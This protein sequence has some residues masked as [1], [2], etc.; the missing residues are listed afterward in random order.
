MSQNFAEE[1]VAADTVFAVGPY[2]RKIG[3]N[4]LL[5]EGP[6]LENHLR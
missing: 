3:G 4:V 6:W 2:S 5:R 1:D